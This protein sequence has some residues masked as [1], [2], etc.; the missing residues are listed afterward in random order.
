[1]SL[2]SIFKPQRHYCGDAFHQ[3]DALEFPLEGYDFIWASPPCQ[4]FS[5]LRFLPCA[6]AGKQH[7]A[8]VLSP[9]S[10]RIHNG[11]C[12]DAPQTH[13]IGVFRS[14]NSL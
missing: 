10:R 6:D 13:D 7:K 3:A 8:R 9:R 14:A 2:E 11:T 5:Q 1:M 4:S 12:S